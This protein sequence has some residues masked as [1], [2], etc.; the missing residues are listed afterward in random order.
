[1][2]MKPFS[3]SL[4]EG[5]RGSFCLLL[6]SYA[7]V[8]QF[9]TIALVSIVDDC[10]RLKRTVSLE[11]IALHCVDAIAN[12]SGCELA[13]RWGKLTSFANEIDAVVIVTS[14]MNRGGYA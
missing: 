2:P 6:R 12:N 10:R 3:D 7:V 14:A 13:W 4:D 8:C 9:R 1:M 5:E 11:L